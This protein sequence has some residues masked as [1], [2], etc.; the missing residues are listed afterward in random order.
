MASERL[1][2]HS[3]LGLSSVGTATPA[4]DVGLGGVWRLEA[5]GGGG[6]GWCGSYRPVGAAG[7]TASRW[8]IHVP[9]APPSPG[10]P[11]QGS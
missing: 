9:A 6:G 3:G 10:R 5:G 1:W 11:G 7:G 4:H 8:R 2:G